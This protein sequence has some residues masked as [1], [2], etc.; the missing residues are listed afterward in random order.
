MGVITAIETQKKHPNRR[1]VY[2][3]GAFFCGADEETI[4]ISGLKVG[5]VVDEEDLELLIKNETRKKAMFAAMN[6]LAIRERSTREIRTS[7]AR[8]GYEEDVIE[9]TLQRLGETNMINDD[10]FAE[11]LVSSKTKEGAKPVGAV[12]IK[13]D[14]YEKGIDPK[15]IREIVDSLDP[16]EELE[17]AKRAVVKKY[18]VEGDLSSFAPDRALKSKIYAFL[19]GRGFTYST[20]ER[21]FS[22][23]AEE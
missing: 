14:L 13:R 19:C 21:L 22:S 16:E 6:L 11:L 7:L 18:R 1:S 4:Y 2:V 10:R 23:F 17:R 20:I 5:D 3:D 9:S 8:K 15:K 12:R